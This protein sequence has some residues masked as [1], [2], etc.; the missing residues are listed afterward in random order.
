MA[1]DGVQRDGQLGADLASR[2]PVR[3]TPENGELGRAWLLNELAL[4]GG[5]LGCGK[6]VL[7]S[8]RDRR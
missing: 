3:K 2:E 6:T 4:P 5:R 8:S 7:N 1:L